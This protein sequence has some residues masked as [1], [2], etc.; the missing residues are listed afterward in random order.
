MCA[1]KS[2]ATTSN[3]RILRPT[4]S[5]VNALALILADSGNGLRIK[6]ERSLGDEISVS[7]AAPKGHLLSNHG[8]PAPLVPTHHHPAPVAQ[9]SFGTGLPPEGDNMDGQR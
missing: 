8:Q 2:S 3:A 5:N 9:V 6:S 7:S 1:D 4:V